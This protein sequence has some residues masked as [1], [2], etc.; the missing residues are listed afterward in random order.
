MIFLGHDLL[1]SAIFSDE[2]IWDVDMVVFTLVSPHSLITPRACA[3]ARGKVI[4]SVCQH[5][6]CQICPQD[7]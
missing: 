7:G 2:Y 3:I 4:G 6:N 1:G 5:K